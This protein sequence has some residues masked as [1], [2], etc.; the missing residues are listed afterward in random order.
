[1]SQIVSLYSDIYHI[2]TILI[3]G[4]MAKADIIQNEFA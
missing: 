1:M 4:G 3:T 2:N